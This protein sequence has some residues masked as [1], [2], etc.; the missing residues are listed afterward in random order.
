MAKVAHIRFS[1]DQ[2]CAVKAAAKSAGL[3]V[4]AFV[5]ALSLEGAGL[6][7]FLSEAD[8]PIIDLLGKHLLAIGNNL[9]QVARAIN[10]GRS[11]GTSD[12]AKAVADA[13]A[14]ANTVAVEFADMTKRAAATRRGR[15]G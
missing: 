9:N 13:R 10:A 15:A 4:S 3:S 5:R 7:P 12:V 6:R 8:R 2:F 14:I 1:Q 11:V